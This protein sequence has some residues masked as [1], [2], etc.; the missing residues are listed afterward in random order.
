MRPVPV[1]ALRQ[2]AR[3]GADELD[4]ALA[5]SSTFA[6]VAGC[7]HMRAFIA[8][9]ARTGPRKASAACVSTLSASPWAS[10]A[11]VFAESGAM[12]SGSASDEVRVE[13]PRRLPARQ[14]LE[15]V[16]RDEALRVRA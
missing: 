15:G 14:R 3:L 9:A 6:C 13:V 5:S 12:T 11:S 10:L 16:R 8:G 7:S 4:A 1:L 2:L